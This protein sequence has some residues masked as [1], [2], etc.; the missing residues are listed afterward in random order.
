M[1]LN[2][3]LLSNL[4][5]DEL[6][7]MEN[8]VNSIN[9]NTTTTNNLS[10]NSY[11]HKYNTFLNRP[12]TIKEN[13]GIIFNDDSTAQQTFSSD[14]NIF[15][16]GLKELETESKYLIISGEDR[17]WHL[18]NTLENTFNFHV[19]CGD[20]SLINNNQATSANIRHS[21]ENVVS[22]YCDS[23]IIPN[24]I[25]EDNSRP[26]DVPYLQLSINDIEHISFGTNKSLD[27]TLAIL[28]PKIPLPNTLQDI[29]YL[30][31][32]NTNH[33]KKI[34]NTPKLRLNK[35]NLSLRRYDGQELLDNKLINNRDMLEIKSI[36]FDSINNNLF[37]ETL[38]YFRPDNFKVG[39]II[40]CKNYM[41]RE[42]NLDFQECHKFNSFI[43]RDRGHH[44]LSTSRTNNTD[45]DI[46]YYNL[47][48]IEYPRTVNI[49]TG[50]YEIDEWFQNLLDKT[51]LDS[52]LEYDNT[53]K[54]INSS[55]QIQILLNIS[56][57][58]KSSIYLEKK[59]DIK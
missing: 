35:L 59:N 22:I 41:F 34:Y 45:N 5:N 52:D 39:D 33:Q 38:T 16:N 7:N 25:L 30:E 42:T 40:K 17:P 28:T 8:I 51:S 18:S 24:R 11:N 21:L 6:R 55:L 23:V 53:G 15:N 54:L 4:Y 1:S 37:L 13:L 9:N 26:T 56:T 27:N 57:L 47:I 3:G 29:S 19:E 46:I 14:N 49:L 10:N 44:I 2:K 31:F 12:Q 48:Q 20:I 43:N 36:Y 50:K 58:N 32:I